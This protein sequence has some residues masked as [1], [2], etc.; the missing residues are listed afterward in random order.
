MNQSGHLT[1]V[2]MAI[3]ILSIANI[4]LLVTAVFYRS[5]G[6]PR[7]PKRTP[8]TLIYRIASGDEVFPKLR[9]GLGYMAVGLGMCSQILYCVLLGAW[10]YRWVPFDPGV[11]SVTYLEMKLSNWGELLSAAT[12][13]VALFGRGLRRY[14]GIWVGATTF[15][16]WGLVG[17]GVALKTLFP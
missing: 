11:N 5:A 16:F 14:A 15:Y 1:H 10:K 2:T 13:L 3:R 17:L 6:R 9:T 7:P 4:C 12:V 8:K